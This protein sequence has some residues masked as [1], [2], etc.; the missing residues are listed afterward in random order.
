MQIRLPVGRWRWAFK[1][2]TGAMPSAA[3]SCLLKFELRP[4]PYECGN[5]PG[6]FIRALQLQGKVAVPAMTDFHVV[7]DVRAKTSA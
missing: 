7:H 3:V 6:V 4:R 2:E 1:P 5:R